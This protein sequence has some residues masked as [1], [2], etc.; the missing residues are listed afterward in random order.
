MS[1]FSFLQKP[2]QSILKAVSDYYFHAP[3]GWNRLA[4]TVEKSLATQLAQDIVAAV[5]TGDLPQSTDTKM[6]FVKLFDQRLLD[7]MREDR[8]QYRAYVKFYYQ[9]FKRFHSMDKAVAI[10]SDASERTD[11]FQDALGK[12]FKR[13]DQD[14]FTFAHSAK[15]L[16]L[17]IYLDECKRTLARRE[18]DKNRYFRGA[19][20]LIAAQLSPAVQRKLSV[21]PIDLRILDLKQLRDKQPFCYDLYY[22]KIIEGFKYKELTAFFNKTAVQLKDDFYRCRKKLLNAYQD[23]NRSAL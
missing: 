19:E 16:F 14:D 9:F 17:K 12:Y 4:T 1:L 23:L 6:H 13:I 20:E 5:K 10:V 2:E 22:K 15:A 11:A 7:Q 18:Q 8:K 21:P 3:D